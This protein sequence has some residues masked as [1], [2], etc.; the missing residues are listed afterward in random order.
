MS[1]DAIGT[2]LLWGR[3]MDKKVVDIKDAKPV[4]P[5]AEAN[6]KDQSSKKDTTG[7]SPRGS[8]K[9]PDLI[10]LAESKCELWHDENGEAFATVS[11]KDHREHWAIDSRGFKEWLAR[12][13]FT[14]KIGS[15]GGDIIKDACSHLSAAAKFEGV[16]HET[17][18][19]VMKHG[20]SYWIDLAN[21]AWQAIRIDSSGWQ[22]VSNPP[23]RFLRNRNFRPLPMPVS[24]GSACDLFQLTNIPKEDELLV[25]AWVLECF[26]PDTPYP[27]LE[28]VG[29]QGSAKSTTQKVLRR[30]IDSNE[31]MLRARPKTIEDIYVAAANGHLVS[32]ENLSGLS[33]DM[34]DALCVISTGGG[35]SGRTLYTNKEETIL[36]A[37]N[38][39]VI[40]G[41]NRVIT[42][43]DLLDRTITVSLPLIERRI[44]ELD[45]QK[46]M[47]R[48]VPSI[49]GGLLDL[50][51]GTLRRLPLVELDPK[52]TPR[53]SDFTRLGE[54][55]SQELGN[56]SGHFL[57][58]YI[59]VRREAVSSA[60]DASAVGRSIMSFIESDNYHIGTVGALL[61]RL[62]NFQ[63]EL[64]IDSGDSWPRTPRKLGEELRRLAP[65]L[66]QINIDCS[67]DQKA[68]KDGIH[69]VLQRKN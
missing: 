13:A 31:V 32:Y 37:H 61:V 51:A 18:K 8:A 58:K 57:E 62:N 42:R 35:Y 4:K 15:A 39:I 26:R 50:F 16:Q 6:K 54:A 44:D 21:E 33:A 20:G 34:S 52:K 10:G 28:Q 59:E 68:K 7:S 38:P 24:G 43:P 46:K 1:L 12:T 25:L 48:L 49:F 55:M 65:A 63:K 17:G 67:V 22:I 9:L 69:C 53:M 11:L 60:I 5:K 40:N 27:V 56:K 36:K 66:R 29:E 45:H 3:A 30:L 64:G 23:V 19:R 2:I 47:D 14:E 41:I